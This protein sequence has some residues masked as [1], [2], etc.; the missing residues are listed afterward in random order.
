MA[1]VWSEDHTFSSLAL[2]T[3]EAAAKSGSKAGKDGGCAFYPLRLLGGL[4]YTAVSC[5]CSTDACPGTWLQS[6]SGSNFQSAACEKLVNAT[7]RPWITVSVWSSFAMLSLWESRC[8]PSRS[9]G[10]PCTSRVSVLRAAASCK[11]C[12]PPCR[13]TAVPPWLTASGSFCKW[14]IPGMAA[15]WRWLTHTHCS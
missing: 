5:I 14:T 6:G 4:W 13:E 3:S 15:H 1:A 7:F 12:S 2:R 11:R 9:R 10:P 8:A